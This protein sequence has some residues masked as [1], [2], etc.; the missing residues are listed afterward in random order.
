MSMNVSTECLQCHLSRSLDTARKL[1]SEE[2]ALA[3]AKE[4]MRLMVDA[5]EDMTS[6]G[7]VPGTT[8]LLQKYYGLD[9]DRFREEKEFSNRFILERLDGIQT[10][11]RQQ[12][13]P[14]LA[15]LQYA[16]MGNYIDFSAL[17][18]KVSFD[19]LDGLL[20]QAL[21]MQLDM[22]C[23]RRLREELE[24]GRKL[25]YIT[26]NAGEI[27]FDRLLGEEIARHY[28]HLAITYC[29]RGFP[30]NNDATRE[31]A[32]LVGIPFPLIDNGDNVAGMEMKR[33]SAQARQAMEEADVILSKGMGNTETLYGSGYPVFYA[34]L[35]KCERFV[36]VFQKPMLTPMLVREPG[37]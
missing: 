31:D 19:Q 2:K 24:K 21:D 5:P 37:T 9:P 18:G 35:I 12:A 25:L 20:D 10:R 11:I 7:L 34:F 23:Y 29:V 3:F 13:D 16:V 6:P 22:D 30:V 17:Y 27:C 36:R 4:L 8:A 15:A 32:E 28:P 33:V 26:D 1:G 14:L